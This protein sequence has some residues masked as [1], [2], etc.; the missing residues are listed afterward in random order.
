MARP[1]EF[2]EQ[3]VLAAAAE[4][5]WAKGYEATS[6]RDLVKCTGLSQPSLYNAF[7]DKRELFRRALGQYLDQRMRARITRLSA[8]SSP[9]QAVSRYFDEILALS[10]ADPQQRGCMLVNAALEITGDDPVFQQAVADA[11]DEIRQFFQRSVAAA[12]QA[13]E[14]AAPVAPDEAAALLLSLQ[15]GIRVQA[16]V[17]AD[18]ANLAS[19]VAPTLRLLGLP[20]LSPAPL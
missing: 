20:P 17:G 2:E 6:T 15:L 18:A 3:L 9:A 11:L 13:G 7:G 4:A 14:V 12:Q 5:F 1:R 19:A 16:R 10:A 8:G